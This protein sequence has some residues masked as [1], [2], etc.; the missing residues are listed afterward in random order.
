M[1]NDIKNLDLAKKNITKSIN[2]LGKFS[3]L[4][5]ALEKL[6]EFGIKKDYKNAENIFLS[7]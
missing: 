1:C 7:V 5:L 6:K 4:I 2:C 3:D